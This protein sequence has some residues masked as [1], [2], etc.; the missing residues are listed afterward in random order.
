MWISTTHKGL[1][2]FVLLHWNSPRLTETKSTFVDLS[3]GMHSLT[4]RSTCACHS[5]M[6]CRP[7]GNLWTN[8]NHWSLAKITLGFQTQ[9]DFGPRSTTTH[10]PIHTGNEAKRNCQTFQWQFIG[11]IGLVSGVNRPVRLDVD[12]IPLPPRTRV[13][14]QSSLWVILTAEMRDVF[15]WKTKRKEANVPTCCT[16]DDSEQQEETNG[17]HCSTSVSVLNVSVVSVDY[18]D[19]V[20]VPLSEKSCRP[21][22]QGMSMS[23]TG[24]CFCLKTMQFS[25]FLW[26]AW[27]NKSASTGGSRLIQTRLIRSWRSSEKHFSEIIGQNI[28]VLLSFSLDFVSHINEWIWCIGVQKM[29]ISQNLTFA[30]APWWQKCK[31]KN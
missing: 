3:F 1:L 12:P 17:V 31:L 8:T 21:V 28:P 27:R 26:I 5:S 2:P 16:G 29:F 7:E 20:S 30:T 19:K 6:Q 18:P 15:L 23:A 4:Q 14:A 25:A 10:R 22:G 9:A 13:S 11:S 24:H